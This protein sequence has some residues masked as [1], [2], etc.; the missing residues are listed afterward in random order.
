MT[1]GRLFVVAIVL[2]CGCALI[3]TGCTDLTT[4]GSSTSQA[5]TVSTSVQTT[6]D[7]PT[8]TIKPTTTTTES[9]PTTTTAVTPELALQ[10]FATA[11]EQIAP[12][13]VDRL[14]SDSLT[15][16]VM[17]LE[18]DAENNTVVLI[19]FST[20]TG[21]DDYEMNRDR[22]D[23]QAWDIAQAVALAMYHSGTAEVLQGTPFPP[24]RL[25]LDG[26]EYEVPGNFMTGTTNGEV[27]MFDWLAAAGKR[28][29]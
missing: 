17:T 27:S 16:S 12:S 7:A 6:T 15:E 10:G 28:G 5:T 24:F 22:Y 23:S 19:M 14:K 25:E 11:V 21:A 4:S 2:L 29:V 8:T 3:V 1:V 18:Y 26:I 9:T 20:H 13:V